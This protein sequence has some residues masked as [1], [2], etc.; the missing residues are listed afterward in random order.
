LGL[1]IQDQFGSQNSSNDYLLLKAP[2]FENGSVQIPLVK[3]DENR[4]KSKISMDVFGPLMSVKEAFYNE[5]L[6]IQICSTDD[7]VKLTSSVIGTCVIPL[8]EIG[9]KNAEIIK[10]VAHKGLIWGFMT[11]FLHAIWL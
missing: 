10:T 9:T 7:Q 11:G 4:W 2:F 1:S 5:L 6:I 8:K 3:I